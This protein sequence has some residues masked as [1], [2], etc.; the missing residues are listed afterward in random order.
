M[1]Q[2]MRVVAG[3]GVVLVLV[4]GT[5]TVNPL[6]GGMAQR[7]LSQREE[8]VQAGLSYMTAEPT[9]HPGGVTL[10][11]IVNISAASQVVT[12]TWGRHGDTWLG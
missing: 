9:L 10:D 7:L 11:T 5:D 1:G 3:M 4:V 6:E 2:G 8:L 12:L